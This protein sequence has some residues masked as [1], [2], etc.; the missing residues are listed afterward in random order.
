MA[1][2]SP[3]GLCSRVVK[4]LPMSEL[5][6]REGFEPPV[7]FPVLQFSRLAPSTTRPPLQLLQFYYS[8]NFF[9]GFEGLSPSVSLDYTRPNFQYM[10]FQ[11]RSHQPL[12]HLSSLYIFTIV[13]PLRIG[14]PCPE[15]RVSR[16]VELGEQL[17]NG[18]DTPG[19]HA[20]LLVLPKWGRARRW[21]RSSLPGQSC[22]GLGDCLR[23]RLGAAAGQ[24]AWSHS[25]G[26]GDPV[27]GSGAFA[28]PIASLGP[29]LCIL[30]RAHG[31][32]SRSH[33]R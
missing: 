28:I 3:K 30:R 16:V 5:A 19:I 32:I 17:A 9:W 18:G 6:E 7:Q 15:N 10:G 1:G 31:K 22:I 14:D 11:D 27:P 24:T 12:G 29:V 20:V 33:S 23:Y 2:L 13:W 8:A 26:I 21:W 4:C 25:S